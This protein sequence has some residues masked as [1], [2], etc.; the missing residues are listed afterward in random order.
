MS[1]RIILASMLFSV[2]LKEYYWVKRNPPLTHLVSIKNGFLE[3]PSRPHHQQSTLGKTKRLMCFSTFV[4][5]LSPMNCLFL[6][7]YYFQKTFIP[8][9]PCMSKDVMAL[10]WRSEVS[11]Q[12][13]VLCFHH[14]GSGDW[15]QIFRVGRKCL[16]PW[17][18]SPAAPTPLSTVLFGFAGVT[19]SVESSIDCI[20]KTFIAEGSKHCSGYWRWVWQSTKQ[21]TNTSNW[22]GTWSDELCQGEGR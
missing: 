15:T 9:L 11:F 22:R 21:I 19:L 1:S 3:R 4:C 7:I 13:W 14:L 5:R 20:K 2:M 17:V 8:P 10:V 12:D 18:I 6:V 16:W